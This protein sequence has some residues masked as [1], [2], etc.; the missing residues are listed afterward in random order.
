MAAKRNTG[1]YFKLSP[2]E[3]DLIN[4]RKQLCGISNTSA[5]IRKMALTGLI[6]NLDI[7][8]FEGISKLL[9]V[10]SNNINQIAKRANEA[11]SIYEMDVLEVKELLTSIKSDFGEVLKSVSKLE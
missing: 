7:P 9:R 5:Y 11:G 6:I 3:L 8:Q 4:Q 2:H 1:L 10:T